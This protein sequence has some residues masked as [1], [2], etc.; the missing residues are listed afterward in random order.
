VTLEREASIDMS[1]DREIARIVQLLDSRD[2][3]LVSIGSGRST[4]AGAKAAAFAETWQ[5]RG[6]EIAGVIDWPH[7]AA[8]WLRPALRLTAHDVDAYVVADDA[9]GFAPVARRLIADTG[10]RPERTVAFAE[11]GTEDL[12]DQLGPG[13][14]DGL[15][16]ATAEGGLWYIDGGELVRHRPRSSVP[17]D[18]KQV[19]SRPPREIAPGAIHVPD[20]LSFDQQ[21]ELVEH[22]RRWAAGPAPMR[23]TRLPSGGVM[24]VQTACLGWH[25]LPYRY[26]RTADDVDGARIVPFPG[27]LVDLGQE[28]LSD[29]YG[30]SDEPGYQPDAALINLY[31]R[32]ARLGMHQDKDERSS[33][34]VVSFSIGQACVFRFGNC[35][36]RGRP[37][38]DIELRSGDLFV[39]GGPSRFA[40]HGVPR[41]L[42]AQPGPDVGLADRR[43]NITLRVTGLD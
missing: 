30:T 5:A 6:G 38:A 32:D 39:F 40:Y 2:T 3:A 23:H 9:R 24:S 18:G 43:V 33:E 1:S 8:S 36:S 4:Q 37:Y 7:E 16:G 31:D 22:C 27:W 20:W 14:F 15:A 19:F 25:W 29:A 12:V 28:A 41:V 11:C 13:S 42:P 26:S 35:T 21:L 17:I 10:W 34:P